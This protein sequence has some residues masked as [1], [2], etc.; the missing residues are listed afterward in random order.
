MHIENV[1]VPMASRS[2]NVPDKKTN[3]GGKPPLVLLRSFDHLAIESLGEV[4]MWP[5]IVQPPGR[6]AFV[7]LK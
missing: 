1:P 6:L 3:G 7:Q 5:L 2:V 4:R